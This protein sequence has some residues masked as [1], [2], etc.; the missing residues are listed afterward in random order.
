MTRFRLSKQFLQGIKTV[1]KILGF[2]VATI[3]IMGITPIVHHVPMNNC[4]RG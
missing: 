1:P 2:A 3:D 4:L